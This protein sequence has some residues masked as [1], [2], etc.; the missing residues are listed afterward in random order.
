MVQLV[1]SASV[2][3]AYLHLDGYTT[4]SYTVKVENVLTDFSKSKLQAV[5]AVTNGRSSAVLIPMNEWYDNAQLHEGMYILTVYSGS[6]VYATRLAY[7]RDSA[8]AFSESDYTGYNGTDSNIY[9]V[10]EQ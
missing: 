6:T 10:Y 3:T 1:K 9:K 4:G 8:G 5:S 2:Q 7:I